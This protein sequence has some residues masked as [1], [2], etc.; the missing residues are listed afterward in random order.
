MALDLVVPKGWYTFLEGDGL[1]RLVSVFL[2]KRAD[3]RN[4]CLC[5]LRI[6][7]HVLVRKDTTVIA[8][9]CQTRKLAL[10]LALLRRQRRR[11]LHKANRVVLL[12]HGIELVPDVVRA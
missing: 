11:F 8:P 10:V 6:V 3:I 2:R 4:L 1:L 9:H 5:V 12:K 7:S